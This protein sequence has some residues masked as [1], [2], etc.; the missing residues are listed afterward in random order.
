MAEKAITAARHAGAGLTG[1]L[2]ISFIASV[3]GPRRRKE[4]AEAQK[5]LT[6]RLN[7]L[8]SWF[9]EERARGCLG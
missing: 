2:R 8:L 1:P 7:Q 9:G 4:A 6:R 5:L 3:A